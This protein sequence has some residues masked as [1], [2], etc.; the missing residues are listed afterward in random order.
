[1]RLA[2]QDG[3]EAVRLRDVSR[4]A[5][6]ALGTI[7]R[8]FRSKSD[9]LAAALD[10]ETRQLQEHLQP[11]RIP[12]GEPIDRLTWFFGVATDMLVARPRL[13]GALLRAVASG[14]PEVA[15]KVTRYHDRM[16]SMIRQVMRGGPDHLPTDRE[17][18]VARI[19]QAVWFA[20]LV[21]WAGGLHGVD[22]VKQ[23]TVTA[24]RL[25]L[26]GAPSGRSA[27]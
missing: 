3:F 26:D 10:L 8:R 1:M 5:G 13:T 2:E 15:G 23:E 18:A 27:G 9:L 25:L 6:V 14:D 21:G 4:E 16:T 7:Y 24:A 11:D 12:G 19:L 20:S 17:T 22:K